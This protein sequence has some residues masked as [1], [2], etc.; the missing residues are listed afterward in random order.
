MH[1]YIKNHNTNSDNIIPEQCALFDL[2]IISDIC[3]NMTAYS[4]GLLV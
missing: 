1:K 4:G 3:W 2:C